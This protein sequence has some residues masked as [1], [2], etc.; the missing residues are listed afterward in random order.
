MYIY[1]RFLCAKSAKRFAAICGE[2]IWLI[3]AWSQRRLFRGIKSHSELFNCR[4][5]CFCYEHWTVD[6]ERERENWAANVEQTNLNMQFISHVNIA[7]MRAIVTNHVNIMH[8]FGTF[9]G[10]FKRQCQGIHHNN[11]NNIKN[12]H[13]HTH[14]KTMAMEKMRSTFTTHTNAHLQN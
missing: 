5:R 11:N 9:S 4:R 13:T 8:L 10:R 7:H 14:T 2:L 6:K 1:R 12:A 3:S